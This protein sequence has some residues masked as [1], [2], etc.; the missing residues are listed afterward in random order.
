MWKDQNKFW[1][2]GS[3]KDWETHTLM[4]LPLLWTNQFINS[5]ILQ[6]TGK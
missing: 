4:G 3:P 5:Q 1:E 6:V 2:F